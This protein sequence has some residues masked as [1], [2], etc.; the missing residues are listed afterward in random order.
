MWPL[1]GY[2]RRSLAFHLAESGRGTE[3]HHLLVME[4][5]D[6]DNAWFRLRTTRD[7]LEGY[8]DDVQQARRRIEGPGVGPT[9]RMTLELRYRL[10][11]A[12]VGTPAANLSLTLLGRLLEYGVWT[13][14]AA[15]GHANRI[16]GERQRATTLA[17]IARH[18]PEPD[19]QRIAH[20]ALATDPGPELL[21]LLPPA[22]R[23][24]LVAQLLHR[25]GAADHVLDRAAVLT[26]LAPY[27]G[28]NPG[29]RAAAERLAFAGIDE[30]LL[31][32]AA[33]E[34]YSGYGE[35]VDHDSEA[36]HLHHAEQSARA[37]IAHTRA[38]CRIA[39]ARAL[40]QRRS[41]L[42]DAALA[43]TAG[44]EAE[45][46]RGSALTSLT[47][48][49]RDRPG[50]AR[51]ALTIAY[52]IPFALERAEATA[53]LVPNL[54][55]RT[56]R[57]AQD[58]ALADIRNAA[59]AT[60]MISAVQ[61][62]A[63]L[64]PTWPP[65]PRRAKLNDA[66]ELVG[67]VRAEGRNHHMALSALAPHLAGY[68]DL[69]DR[70]LS[71]LEPHSA[72]GQSWCAAAIGDLAPALGAHPDLVGRAIGIARSIPE[73]AARADAVAGLSPVLSPADRVP[74]LQQAV[75]DLS[76]IG[77]DLACSRAVAGLAAVAAG[78]GQ[79]D[80]MVQLTDELPA[81][82]ERA[83]VL[84]ALAHNADPGPA[85]PWSPRPSKRRAV[86]RRRSRS[87]TASPSWPRASNPA[88][89]VGP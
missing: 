62:I 5:A 39:L 46:Y 29:L 11:L 17:T 15:L 51:R 27:L 8:L 64:A 60:A 71:L 33:R 56:R 58:R 69:L 87:R 88:R 68:R 48:L 66:L 44:I 6:G 83:R 19:R 75:A 34:D 53:R 1:S 47:P 72:L 67:L 42:L 78:P 21:P 14:A 79:L 55:G 18:A 12:S 57:Q 37:E 74:L 25:A 35:W 52:A 65:G 32:A 85:R 2:E 84:S 16:T 24:A 77:D 13:T 63:S 3:L 45:F 31:L 70:A 28:T 49:L 89:C 43:V 9:Q 26:D 41:E 82:A 4:D 81:G 76:V 7:D 86:T 22:D 36:A 23:D 59:D 73:A 61:V 40:P 20:S 54:H 50:L 38:A 10:T 30:D 80:R